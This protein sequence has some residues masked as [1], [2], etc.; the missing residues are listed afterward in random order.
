M[1]FYQYIKEVPC[2]DTDSILENQRR[3]LFKDSYNDLPFCYKLAKEVKAFTDAFIMYNSKYYYH[4]GEF[5]NNRSV[6][7]TVK[8]YFRQAEF[9]IDKP[10]V[11]E[12]IGKGFRQ[13]AGNQEP[14]LV[15]S[16]QQ[17]I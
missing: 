9:S 12:N 3:R 11:K 13:R 4:A 14:A 16:H 7:R 17:C 8:A 6:G 10:V 1:M 5:R 2:Y 15:S